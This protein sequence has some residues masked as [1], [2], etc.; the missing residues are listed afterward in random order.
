MGSPPYDAAVN[1]GTGTGGRWPGLD[2]LRG[3]AVLAVL[4]YHLELPYSVRG[5]TIGVTTFF[6]L[7]GFLITTLLLREAEGRTTVRLRSFYARRALRLLPALAVLVPVVVVYAALA[8]RADDTVAAAPAVAFYGGNWV[9]AFDGFSTLG[10]FE[11]SWSLSVEEQFYLVWPVVVVLVALVAG[12]RHRAQ[13]VLVASLAGAAASLAWRLSLWDGS[14]AP[15]SAARLYNG[16]DTAADQLLIGCALA[17]ALWL[18][19]D[20]AVPAAGRA[21]LGAGGV[22]ALGLL[23]WVAALRPGGATVANTRLYLTWGASAFALAAAVVVAGIVLAPRGAL[24]RALA[25][26]PL[27]AVGRVSYGL[28]LWHYPV[29]VVVREHLDTAG[30]PM[31]WLVAVAVSGLLTVASWVLVE[32]PFL[33]WKDRLGPAAEPSALPSAVPSAVPAAAHRRAQ[34]VGAGRS[35]APAERGHLVSEG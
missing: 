8:G 29:V 27:M 19:R 17:A 7:S 35:A 1:A 5:G 22:A 32:R 9:R 18:L 23:V 24:P 11:H 33:A 25:T 16:T 12:A 3:L 20:R 31:Q 10:L 4:A 30:R 28:Y 2:G 13:A 21:V 26:R 6:V 15:A 34:P 14:D